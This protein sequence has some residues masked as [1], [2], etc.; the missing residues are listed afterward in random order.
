MPVEFAQNLED[1]PMTLKQQVFFVHNGSSPWQNPQFG[2]GTC[3][4]WQ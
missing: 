4:N 1:L 2:G 3:N